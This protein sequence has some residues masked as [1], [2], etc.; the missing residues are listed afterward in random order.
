MFLFVFVLVCIR[1][2]YFASSLTLYIFLT[3]RLHHIRSLFGHRFV[4]FVHQVRT[5]SH[6]FPHT[7][8]SFLTNRLHSNLTDC[9]FKL[10]QL[11]V[12]VPV[13]GDGIALGLT[14]NVRRF[15][16]ACLACHRQ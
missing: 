1:D 3:T 4:S 10:H 13:V 16:L 14:C 9:H 8:I 12:L 11:M 6:H 2:P 5:N 7:A 15:L